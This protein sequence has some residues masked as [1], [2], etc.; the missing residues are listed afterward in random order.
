M[1]L[2]L[3]ICSILLTNFDHLAHQ[4]C[5]NEFVG[6]CQLPTQFSHQIDTKDSSPEHLPM[7]LIQNLLDPEMNIKLK[8]NYN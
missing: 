5:M 3:V 1:K 6:V 8:L 2:Y 4:N 7:N